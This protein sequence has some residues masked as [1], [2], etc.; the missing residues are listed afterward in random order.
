MEKLLTLFVLVIV[1]VLTSFVIMIVEL[2]SGCQKGKP[3]KEPIDEKV[4]L[5]I[6]I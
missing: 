2:C 3:I 6:G 4:I 1:G 5:M